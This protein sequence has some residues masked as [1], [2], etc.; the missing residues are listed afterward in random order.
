MLVLSRSG[1]DYIKEQHEGVFNTVEQ[2]SSRRETIVEKLARSN[3]ESSIVANDCLE[4]S[5]KLLRT[6]EKSSRVLP[7]EGGNKE[8]EEE[9]EVGHICS[10]S[11]KVSSC[12]I[13]PV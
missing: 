9:Q 4:G 11:S 13:L 10:S 8:E 1:F 2:A 5:G 12:A 3:M 7:E 6:W